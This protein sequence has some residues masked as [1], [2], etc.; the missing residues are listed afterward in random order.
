[1]LKPVY[2]IL[3]FLSLLFGALGL[4]LPLLPTVP[5]ILVAAFFFSKGSQ[6]LEAWLLSHRLFGPSI[7]AWRQTGSISGVAKRSAYAAFSLSALLGV[8]F[9]RVPWTFLS[10]AVALLGSAW[11]YTRPEQ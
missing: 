11:I 8:L 1:M 9:L 4:F 5:F 2:L 10:L 6:R 7:R 3:G